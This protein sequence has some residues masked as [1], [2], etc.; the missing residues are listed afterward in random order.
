MNHLDI[1]PRYAAILMGFSN[2]IGTL[3]G[4]TCPFVTEKF[5]ARVSKTIIISLQLNVV[6][7]TKRASFR[8]QC[9]DQPRF[10]YKQFRCSVLILLYLGTAWLAKGLSTR[11]FDPFYWRHLLC[12][13]CIR[14]AS[15]SIN[16][17]QSLANV[18]SNAILP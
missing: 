16:W 3:A 9:D 12:R 4:L 2:G 7:F 11:Q 18:S 6:Y 1:A 10:Q 15:G 5:T 14:R 8:N 13:L 17:H